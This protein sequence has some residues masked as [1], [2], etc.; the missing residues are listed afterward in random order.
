[1][2]LITVLLILVLVAKVTRVVEKVAVKRDKT[3]KYLA[4]IAAKGLIV[5]AI[6][7]LINVA[8]RL[9]KIL[10]VLKTRGIL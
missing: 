8:G 1:M 2:L 4:L 9:V 7:A 3:L 6:A 10:A 5:P